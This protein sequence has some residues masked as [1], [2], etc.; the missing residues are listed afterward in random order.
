MRTTATLVALA[1]FSIGSTIAGPAHS[2]L[3]RKDT[4][5]KKGQYDNVDWDLVN[6]SEIGINWETVNYGGGSSTVAAAQTTQAATVATTA[7]A[8]VVP[9]TTASVSSSSPSAS[10]SSASPVNGL[11][12]WVFMGLWNNLEGI[13]NSLTEFGGSTPPSGSA[14]SYVGN[15]GRPYASVCMLV[16]EVGCNDYT[17]TVQNSGSDSITINLWLKAGPDGQANSGFALAPTK[18][19]LTFNVPA[20]KSQVVAFAEN[21][22]GA[23]CEAT[24]DLDTTCGGFATTWLEFNMVSG[25]PAFDVS[26][27]LNPSKGSYQMSATADECDCTSDLTNNSWVTADDQLGS[28]DCAISGNAAHITVTMGG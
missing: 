1:A 11:E 12:S 16:S 9:T 6:W 10:S 5:E 4:L 15:V 28:G 2:H 26:Q 7:A 23:L 22:Q 8:A 13:S 27:I 21:V 14:V 17:I 25:W 19:A 24:D 20:G 3:H 18:T